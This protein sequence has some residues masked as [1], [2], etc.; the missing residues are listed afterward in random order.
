[1]RGVLYEYAMLE[2]ISEAR[3]SPARIYGD[4]LKVENA[5]P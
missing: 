1:M 4:R 2:T 3:A 5:L